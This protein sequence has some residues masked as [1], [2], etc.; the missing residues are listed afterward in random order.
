MARELLG[1]WRC[2]FLELAG[3]PR[4]PIGNTHSLGEIAA[5]RWPGG[6]IALDFAHEQRIRFK[7]K[8]QPAF[9]IAC[10]M[11]SAA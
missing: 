1:D 11:A 3:V 9:G 2:R 10:R 7:A 4:N 5:G 8:L 6:R